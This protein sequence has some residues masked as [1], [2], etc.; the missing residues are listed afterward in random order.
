MS[1][2]LHQVSYCFIKLK[3]VE[4]KHLWLKYNTASLELTIKETRL[5]KLFLL[6]LLFSCF[7]GTILFLCENYLLHSSLCFLF[8]KLLI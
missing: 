2:H 3:L 7:G 4:V 6:I 5:L 8:V 1:V